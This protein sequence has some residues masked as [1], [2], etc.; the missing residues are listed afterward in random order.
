MKRNVGLTDIAIRNEI[1]PGDLG[2]LIHLHGL[3]Y[4][5]EYGYG[6][7][8]ETYVA[9]GVAEFYEN[10]DPDRDGV[11]ICEHAGRMIGF[12]LT[13]H[14]GMYSAQLRYFLISPE[15]RGIGLGK[16]L[17][18]LSMEFLTEHRYRSAYLWTTHELYVAASLY[19]RHGFALAEEKP[20]TAFGKPLREQRYDLVLPRQ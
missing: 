2:Y 11:W 19:K 1:R 16:Q 10:Y 5:Q 20:S 14:R 15:Y 8:F 13:M 18:Q 9:E 7:R 17:M 12:L 4:S 6:I 3:L